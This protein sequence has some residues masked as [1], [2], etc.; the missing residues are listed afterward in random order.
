MIGIIASEGADGQLVTGAEA[1]NGSQVLL[2]RAEVDEDRREP[3]ND[4]QGYIIGL[5]QVAGVYEQVAGAARDGRLDSAIAEVEFGGFRGSL[6]GLE[7]GASAF[8]GCL[9]GAGR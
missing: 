4:H 1:P 3:V 2:G 9:S 5:D 6:V 7:C 8:N